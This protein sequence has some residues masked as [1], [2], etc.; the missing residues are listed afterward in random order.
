MAM[1]NSYVSHYRR[2]NTT[3]DVRLKNQPDSGATAL[4]LAIAHGHRDIVTHL[5][6]NGTGDAAMPKRRKIRQE[7]LNE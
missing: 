7:E 6:R 1:F 3:K 5:L 2:V 4:N